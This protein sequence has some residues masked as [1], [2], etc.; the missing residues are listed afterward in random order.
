MYLVVRLL[1]LVAFAV[2]SVSAALLTSAGSG[3]LEDLS[4]RAGIGYGFTSGPVTLP[5]GII[6]T[7][8]EN[9]VLGSGFYG[10]DANGD[11][12]GGSWYYMGLDA[13]EGWM[14]LELPTLVSEFTMF[15]NYDPGLDFNPMIV[16]LDASMNVLESYDLSVSAPISTP[17]GENAGAYRGIFRAEG[18][19]KYIE[20]RNAL[21]VAKDIR[22]LE[23]ESEV[24]EPNSMALLSIGALGGLLLRRRR[25]H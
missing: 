14:R 1:L 19:I 22:F 9:A 5:S 20:L 11:W 25:V 12:F 23:V 16:A 17:G 7:S 8:S 6:F 24:P 4:S 21:I 15:V 13:E 3:T 2:S 18:D 10:L